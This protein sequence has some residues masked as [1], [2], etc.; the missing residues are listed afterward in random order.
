MERMPSASQP[1][2]EHPETRKKPMRLLALS[3]TSEKKEKFLD[4][5]KLSGSPNI[6][7]SG[8]HKQIPSWYV[9]KKLFVAVFTNC[10]EYSPPENES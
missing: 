9:S 8:N 10:K 5:M 7:I 1:P 3:W 6:Q 2:P 4:I